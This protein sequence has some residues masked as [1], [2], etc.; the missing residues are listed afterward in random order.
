MERNLTLSQK[1][2]RRLVVLNG[3]EKRELAMVEAAEIM[4]VSQRQGWRLLAAYRKEGA[5]GLA[6]GNRGRKPVNCLA[7]EIR[8]R[9]IGLAQKKYEGFNHQHMTEELGEREGLEL[10][11]SSVRRILLGAG[12]A[13]PRRRRPRRHRRRRER[14]IQEGMLL[15]MDGSPHDWLEGR[16]PHLTLIAGIDDATGKVPAAVFRLQEDAQGYFL[17][18]RQVVEKMGLPLAVYHDRHG[19]FERHPWKQEPSLQEQLLGQEPTTQMGRLLKEL[20][21]ASIA[22]RSP[23]A[24]GR[25]ERLFGTFQ[26]RL[27]SE[28]RLAK[29]KTLEEANRVLRAFVRRF[30]RRF[31]VPAAKPAVA[32]QSVS[33]ERNLDEVFCF[34]Y[35]RTVGADNVVALGKQRIQI[36]PCNG[37]QSYYR[38]RVEV[39]QRMDGSL[40]VYYQGQCLATLPAPLEAPVLRVQKRGRPSSVNSFTSPDLSSKPTKKLLSKKQRTRPKPAPDHPWINP[41]RRKLPWR[42]MLPTDIFADQLT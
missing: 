8:D 35:D 29:A 2:Q 14:Y 10:S 5:A 31:A 7:Q 9:V 41:W 37:R 33:K 28:L 30:N 39:H 16:G 1:E 18:L 24:K 3:V 32:Y 34:K 25:I 27:R 42:K 38:A 36:K 4:G 11:R 23:Q 13:S 19:I 15:Q 6:H 21:I 17:M 26:D 20:G 40:G 12:M 22:A